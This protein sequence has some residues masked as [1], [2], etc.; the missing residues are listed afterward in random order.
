MG[1]E[2]EGKVLGGPEAG[3]GKGG[4]KIYDRVLISTGEEVQ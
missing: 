3:K 2:Q 4:A 1:K